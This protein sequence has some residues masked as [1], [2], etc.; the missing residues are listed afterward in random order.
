M[1]KVVYVFQERFDEFVPRQCIVESTKTKEDKM[2]ASSQ[3]CQIELCDAR[4]SGKSR[5]VRLL[6]FSIGRCVESNNYTIPTVDSPKIYIIPFRSK[7]HEF[8]HICCKY[9]QKK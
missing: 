6:D 2:N 8:E 1:L 4:M 5:F 7:L 3:F 9:L